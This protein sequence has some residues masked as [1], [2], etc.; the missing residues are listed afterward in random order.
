[1]SLPRSDAEGRLVWI[2]DR[3]QWPRACLRAELIE[4]GHD[5][6]GFETL[7][8]ALFALERQPP[9]AVLVVDLTGQA[10]Q[11][12]ALPAFARRGC[13]LLIIAGAVEAAAAR[14]APP[15][16][17]LARPVTLGEIADEVDRL[18]GPEPVRPG[19]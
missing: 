14:A 4:R 2:V 8:D 16:T 11:A 7:P 18:L 12:R 5:A 13:R 1:M 6:V 3:E 15:A 17:L 10:A 19:A 9:P